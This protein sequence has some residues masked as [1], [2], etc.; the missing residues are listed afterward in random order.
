MKLS[1][2]Y[3]VFNDNPLMSFEEDK[4][5]L[6]GL[7]LFLM[8][9]LAVPSIIAAV[10]EYALFEKSFA[11][12][13]YIVF[14]FPII[15]ALLFRK[16]ISYKHVV[17][18]IIFSAYMIGTL[19]IYNEGFFGSAIPIYITMVALCTLLLG[20]REGIILLAVCFATLIVA[21]ILFSTNLLHISNE[22]KESSTKIISWIAVIVS[23]PY[24]GGI[25]AFII[26]R[27]N[28]KLIANLN[29]NKNQANLLEAANNELLSIKNNLEELVKKRTSEIEEKT[30]LL[31]ESNNILKQK[32]QEMENYNRLFVGREF[33]IKELK[34]KIKELEEL[35]KKQTN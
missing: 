18:L 19:I 17:Y 4:E 5:K 34:D 32:N 8:N 6:L 22:I 3:F 10:L 7:I 33:R 9:I 25:I 20:F 16:K 26:A 14:F 1:K 27:I 30:N 31:L 15:I 12:L 11:G 21:S 28:K 13:M 2:E 29:Y 35:I 24:L 23:F